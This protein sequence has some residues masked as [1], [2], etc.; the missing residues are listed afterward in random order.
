MPTSTNP[1]QSLRESAF[2][3]MTRDD[4]DYSPADDRALAA[5]FAEEIA[6]DRWLPP[7]E[8][9]RHRAYQCFRMSV[10]DLAFHALSAPPPYLQA[11]EVNAVAGG[12][13]RAFTILDPEHPV[14]AITARI[15]AT[16]ARQ[17]LAAGVLDGQAT[18]NC[19]VDAHY[20]RIYAPGKPCP[21]GIHRDGL[22]AGSAHLVRRVNITGA[23]SLLYDLSGR[24]VHKCVLTEPLDSFVFDDAQVMHYTNDIEVSEPG[25][26]AFRDVLLIGFRTA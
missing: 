9:Y 12:V 2:S 3:I 22:I 6:L 7:G 26:P 20:I 1:Q 13:A 19:L 10:R 21:E 18:P 5:A 17:L 8:T 11:K 4:F 16:V 15:A 23:D 24:E 25:S 14:T